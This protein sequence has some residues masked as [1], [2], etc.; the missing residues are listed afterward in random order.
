M[1]CSFIMIQNY[2]YYILIPC[3][4]HVHLQM[5]LSEAMLVRVPSALAFLMS[6]GWHIHIIR[7]AELFEGRFFLTLTQYLSSSS[8]SPSSF[9]LP[10]VLTSSEDLMFDT[11]FPT[12]VEPRTERW[13]EGGGYR[14]FVDH[15]FSIQLK[16][17]FLWLINYHYVCQTLVPEPVTLASLRLWC[18]IIMLSGISQKQEFKYPLVF[19]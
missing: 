11:T 18:R 9:R 8:L 2:Q 10:Q 3:S 13:S 14:T 1:G 5:L 19:L 15:F 12:K 4:F 17:Y 7:K 16:E 6:L